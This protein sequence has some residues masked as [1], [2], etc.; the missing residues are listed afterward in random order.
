MDISALQTYYAFVQSVSFDP[1]GSG[2][3]DHVA[4]V[5][6]N[7]SDQ[8]VYLH[9]YDTRTGEYKGKQW[10]GEMTWMFDKSGLIRARNYETN[11]YLSITAGD[12]DG[13]GK[14]TLII[15]VPHT[16]RSTTLTQT[17]E[18]G[19]YVGCFL[20]EYSFI[21]NKDVYKRQGQVASQTMQ[22]L[23]VTNDAAAL[24]V[25]RPLIGCLLYTSDNLGAKGVRRDHVRSF[26][27]D[28]KIAI[29]VQ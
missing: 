23:A 24:P 22:A 3:R 1:F 29:Q 18:Y 6:L 19:P 25:F 14:D 27:Q 2:R 28:G 21:G 16:K 8:Q 9:I 15:Y 7:K 10:V 26:Q 5:G 20:Y 17:L 4:Y 11:A 13:D 12:F